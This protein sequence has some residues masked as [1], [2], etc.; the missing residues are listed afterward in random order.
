MGLSKERENSVEHHEIIT[1]PTIQMFSCRSSQRKKPKAPTPGMLKPAFLTHHIARFH[2]KL[3]IASESLMAYLYYLSFAA[4]P[5]QRASP[6]CQMQF[7][8]IKKKALHT[9]ALHTERRVSGCALGRTWSK[10]SPKS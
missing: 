5:S 6:V 3:A 1:D 7:T 9:C 8:R 2:Q 10:L 4:S